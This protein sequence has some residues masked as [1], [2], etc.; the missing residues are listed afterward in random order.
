MKYTEKRLDFQRVLAACQR[1]VAG[2]FC[3]VGIGNAQAVDWPL[4]AAAP[5]RFV[6]TFAEWQTYERYFAPFTAMTV[7]GMDR[8]ESG[9]FLAK[10][11]YGQRGTAS[12]SQIEGEWYPVLGR[13]SYAYVGY[14]VGLKAPYPRHRGGIEYFTALPSA[15]EASLGVRS[16]VFRDGRTVTLLTGSAAKYA[17]NFWI[18]LRPFVSVNLSGTSASVLVN[19]RYYLGDRDEFMYVRGGAG[20]IPDE[21]FSMSTTGLPTTEIFVLH[22]LSAG[23]GIQWYAWKGF[24]LSAE[25]NLIRQ[26]LGF[27]RG[28]YIWNPSLVAGIRYSLR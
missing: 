28:S 24:L 19:G 10:V 18:S 2:L 4:P 15:F 12:G 1:V 27:Q 13:G 9:T 25:A 16:Y 23:A 17:G 7:Y 14:A 22:A 3:V 26:E 6:G 21:R 8:R 20:V 11:T 5:E